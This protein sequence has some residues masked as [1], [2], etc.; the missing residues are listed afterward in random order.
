MLGEGKR[1]ERGEKKWGMKKYKD[2]PES[3]KELRVKT[4]N[5]RIKITKIRNVQDKEEG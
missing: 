2:N 1:A 3:E 4:K 5:E